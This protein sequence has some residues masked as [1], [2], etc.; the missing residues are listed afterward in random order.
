MMKAPGGS[1]AC[2]SRAGFEAKPQG[3][4]QGLHGAG[5]AGAK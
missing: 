4:F 5:G 1:G 3:F 2:I